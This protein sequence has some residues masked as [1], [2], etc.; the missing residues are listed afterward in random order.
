MKFYEKS[1]SYLHN[2]QETLA[3]VY[4]CVRVNVCIY[5]INVR[6]LVENTLIA[7]CKVSLLLKMTLS[8]FFSYD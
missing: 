3:C 7:A 6:G 5:R 1:Q 2:S 4:V 8:L